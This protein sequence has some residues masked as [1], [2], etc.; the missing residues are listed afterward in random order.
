MVAG[1]FGLLSVILD[2][3]PILASMVVDCIGVIL[4]AAAGIWWSFAMKGTYCKSSIF[5]KDRLWKGFCRRALA[6]EIFL[7]L[8]MTTLCILL[9]LGYLQDKRKGHQ[10][11]PSQAGV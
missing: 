10:A 4:F 9:G 5:H 2:T 6:D 11:R 1:V 8:G 7:F 3:I